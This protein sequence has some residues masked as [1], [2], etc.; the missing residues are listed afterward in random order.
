MRDYQRGHVEPP[1]P[2]KATVELPDRVTEDRNALLQHAAI[3]LY[4]AVGE[5]ETIREALGATNEHVYE[6]IQIAAGIQ[7]LNDVAKR[8][9]PRRQVRG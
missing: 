9:E 8:L 1:P 3:R 4:N 7:I 2:E 6:R 5:A